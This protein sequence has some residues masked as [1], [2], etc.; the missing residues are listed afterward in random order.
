MHDG[1]FFCNT[2]DEYFGPQLDCSFGPILTNTF[3]FLDVICFGS[4][5]VNSFQMI[6]EDTPIDGLKNIVMSLKRSGTK[7][8]SH[9][10]K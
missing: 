7:W 9:L 1:R 3:L 5:S 10:R 6:Q 8:K 2:S 4:V